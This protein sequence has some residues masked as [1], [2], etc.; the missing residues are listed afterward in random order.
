MTAP[1]VDERIRERIQPVMERMEQSI[2]RSN[3]E[4]IQ[5]DPERYKLTRLFDGPMR[6]R[7]WR[8]KDG[9]GTAI[10]WCYCTTPNAAGYYLVWRERRFKDGRMVRDQWRATERRIDAGRLAKAMRA[11]AG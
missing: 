8:S 11:E 6:W 2:H 3:L 10:R 4:R 5:A 1:T 9:R 7:Y